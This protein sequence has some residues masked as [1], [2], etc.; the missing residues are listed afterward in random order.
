MRTLTWLL[1]A[2]VVSAACTPRARADLDAAE[3]RAAI[4]RGIHWLKSQQKVDGSWPEWTGFPGGVTSLATLALL[5]SGVDPSDEHVQSALRYLRTME[6]QRTYTTALQTMVFCA[7][8]P[9]R[10]MPLIRRNVTWFENNQIKQGANRGGWSYPGAGALGADN[11]NSQFALLALHEAHRV[12]AS[13]SE[14]TWRAA[15]AYWQNGQNPNGSWGYQPRDGGTGSMTC[16]GISSMAIAL[17]VLEH[18][19]AQVVDGQVRCCGMQMQNTSVERG[20]DWLGRNFS[21]QANPG[22]GNSWVLY[23]LYGV[24]RVG[25][26]TS[27]RFIGAHDWYRE[28]AEMFVR[29]QD[30]L[31]GFWKGRGHGEDNPHVATSFA[32]LFLSKGRR[33][34][35]LAKLKHGTDDDWNRHRNAVNNLTRYVESRWNRELSS[36]IIDPRAASVDDLLQAPVLYF[37]GRNRP[38]FSEEQ[39]K[40]LRSYIDHGGFIFA[41]SCCEGGDFDAGFRELMEQVFPEPQYPL[42]LLPPEHPVWR[43]E[44]PIDPQRV[45]PLYGI[46]FGCRTSVIYCPEDLSCYWELARA[47]RTDKLPPSV[48]PDVEAANSIG[49][50]VLAYATNRELRYKDE[51]PTSIVG[52]EGQPT[53]DRAKLYIAKLRHGGGWNQAPQALVQLEKA[54]SREAGLHVDTDRHDVSLGDERLFN[55]PIVFMHGRND[56]RLDAAQREALRTYVER[57][58]FVVADSIC[59]SQAFTNAVRRELAAVFPDHPL[60]RIPTDAPLLT[61]VY[62]GFDIQTVTRRQPRQAGA[63]GRLETVQRQVPPELDAIEIDGRYGVIFSPYDLSCALERH[64]SLEC[65]GYT[66]DDAARIAINLVLYALHE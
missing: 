66:R 43:A 47:G 17:E 33:P 22:R 45:P 10:D 49:V 25:R 21:S 7:A 8:E 15:L 4:D 58:G 54:L 6:P 2:M 3:V 57:G 59:A 50:N 40:N 12:G 44:E 48:R 39:V 20:L 30:R 37:D 51:I 56:F 9:R 63:D 32:L 61:P 35:V 64:E 13:A 53:L 60:E 1:I 38:R 65:E 26:L 41:T 16:A 27:R 5:Q 46:N 36:Q 14:G 31:S 55:Y 34:V 24:E 29:T 42:D 28:G 62:G 52:D 19:D 18:G 11:S 23:Y